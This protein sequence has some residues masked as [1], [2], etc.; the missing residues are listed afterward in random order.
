MRK[1][2]LVHGRTNRRSDPSDTS[3][4]SCGGTRGPMWQRPGWR[5]TVLRPMSSGPGRRVGWATSRADTLAVMAEISV[6]LDDGGRAHIALAHGGGEVRDRVPLDELAEA[7][8]VPALDALVLEFDFYGRLIGIEVT[9]A[10]ASVL[11]P[12]LLDS[13][14]RT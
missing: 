11:P 10:A 13:A 2:P 14:E 3:S 7:E 1:S 9:N 6:T 4:T 12:A 8:A 5:T